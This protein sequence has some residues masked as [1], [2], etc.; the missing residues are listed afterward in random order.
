MSKYKEKIIFKYNNLIKN[1]N[2]YHSVNIYIYSIS[3]N[4]R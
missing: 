2:E 3:S 4:F 1:K